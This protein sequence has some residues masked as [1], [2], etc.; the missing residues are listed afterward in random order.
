MGLSDLVIGLS[1][2]TLGWFFESKDQMYLIDLCFSQRRR[3]VC[4]LCI[5]YDPSRAA[6]ETQGC[7]DSC[8]VPPPPPTPTPPA[9]RLR[10]STFSGKLTK[11]QS[12]AENFPFCTIDLNQSRVP[13]PHQRS[14]FSPP[15]FPELARYELSLCA[16]YSHFTYA[17]TF[18][19]FSIS[20]ISPEKQFHLK[21]Q[22]Y[23][24]WATL[25]YCHNPQKV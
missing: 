11:S 20:P 1:V 10:K 3:G 19:L 17:A 13:T 14:H 8:A 22:S 2:L 23:K 4:S 6:A 16:Y 9:P 21:P 18:C 5:V 12:A 25:S 7:V 24:T 15:I